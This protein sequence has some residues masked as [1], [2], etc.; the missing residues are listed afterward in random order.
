[1][2]GLGPTIESEEFLVGGNAR[3]YYGTS[4]H[5]CFGPEVSIFPFQ[6]P[7]DQFEQRIVELNFN[8]HYLFEL[9]HRFEF[10]PLSGINYTREEGRSTLDMEDS[11][12][13]KALGINFGVGVHYM[14]IDN[15]F[16][17]AEYK[18]VIGELNDGFFTLGAVF[19]LTRP[20][21]QSHD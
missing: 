20:K 2:G 15:L 6:S 12:V 19:M 3:I 10:Y 17:F 4:P 8:A 5:F 9:A 13:D 18:E 11:E 1:M 21:H 14:L 16:V 7:A